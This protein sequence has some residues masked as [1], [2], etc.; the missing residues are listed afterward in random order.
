MSYKIIQQEILVIFHNNK[1]ETV[2]IS[3]NKPAMTDDTLL[4]MLNQRT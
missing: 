3:V 2:K 4:F 1:E